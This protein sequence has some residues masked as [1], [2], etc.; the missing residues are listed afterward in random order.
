M[1]NLKLEQ[2]YKLKTLTVPS[3]E[4]TVDRFVADYVR[5]ERSPRT[6]EIYARLVTEL[7]AHLHKDFREVTIDD[8]NSFVDHKA[9]QCES[10]KSMMLYKVVLKTFFKWLYDMKGTDYP[11]CVSKLATTSRRNGGNA[12][13]I[14]A[15]DVLTK[16]DIAF[17]VKHCENDRDEAIV[18]TLYES[19]ARVGEFC[20]MSVGDLA[21]DPHGKK[22][23]ISGKTGPRTIL[24]VESVSYINKWLSH[25]AGTLSPDAPLWCALKSP[26]EPLT[27]WQVEGLLRDLKKRSGIQKKLNPHNFRHSRATYLAKYLSDAQMRVYFGWCKSSNMQ[28]VYTHL[29][30]RDNDG[31]ILLSA[32]IQETENVVETS[33][34]A[35]QVCPKCRTMNTGTAIYC[36]TC[37]RPFKEE[38]VV[39]ENNEVGQLRTRLEE[40]TE[41]VTKMLQNPKSAGV[42]L[43]EFEGIASKLGEA[44]EL[45][46]AK[47]IEGKCT[48]GSGPDGE[49]IK[50]WMMGEHTKVR[51]YKCGNGH[52]FKTYEKLNIKTIAETTV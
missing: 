22:I 45:H 5:N 28:Q 2:R 1:L 4:Q 23:T 49:P 17:E 11:E 10:S 39:P 27:T 37:G 50:T 7:D 43:S 38:S 24:L 51:L 33:P 34:L 52:R 26:H 32:G 20:N 48:C 18:T 29:S 31:A 8:I 19:G 3:N 25:Y 41:V 47:R 35:A 15:K 14:E 16:E 42:V 9:T 44:S 36:S 46:E 40:L 21:D 30:G 13:S 6:I 12:D